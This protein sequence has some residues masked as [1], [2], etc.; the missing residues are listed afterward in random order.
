MA[1]NPIEELIPLGFLQL[2]FVSTKKEQVL[3]GLLLFF[4]FYIGF[5]V[6]FFK[7]FS[8]DYLER[9]MDYVFEKH[10]FLVNK[11]IVCNFR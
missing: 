4:S 3:E 7:G 10:F 5:Y 2:V 9:M 1:I 6:S 11:V 8:F